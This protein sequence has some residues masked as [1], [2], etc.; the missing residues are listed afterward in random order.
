MD[1]VG[2]LARSHRLRLFDGE[3]TYRSNRDC[4][5]EECRVCGL[6]EFLDRESTGPV[7]TRKEESGMCG[8]EEMGEWVDA[9]RRTKENVFVLILGKDCYT[10][11]L[12]L[13]KLNAEY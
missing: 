11:Q 6:G 1:D 7:R 8:L 9:D 5:I 12:I 3:S 2:N 13:K 4:R 10:K